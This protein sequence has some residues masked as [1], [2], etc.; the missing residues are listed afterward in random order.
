MRKHFSGIQLAHGRNPSTDDLR[1]LAD[2]HVLLINIFRSSPGLLLTVVPLLEQNLK[3]ADEIPL[4]Q[5]STRTLGRMF[6]ERPIVGT[7]RADLAKAYPSA[8]RAW[9]GRKVDKALNVR[10]AWVESTRGILC[11]HPEL[12]TELESE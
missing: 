7:G 12:R 8:W 1:A 2:S 10:L 9:L 3:A 6:G 5:L 4:R 11:N